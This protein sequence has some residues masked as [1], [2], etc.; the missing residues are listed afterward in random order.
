MI[1]T[2]LLEKKWIKYSGVFVLLSLVFCIGLLCCI[3]YYDKIDLHLRLN[4]THTPFED[5]FYA[6]YTHVGEWVPYVI[7]ALL[8]F[9]KAGWAS[10]LLADVL[11]SGL[12]GQIVK[13]IFNTDRP[14]LYFSR[15][16]PDIQL[17]FVD[18]VELSQWYS[19]PSGHTTTF[20]AL[21][22]TLAIVLCEWTDICTGVCRRRA[23]G[24]P[25]ASRRMKQ[26]LVGCLP[27]VDRRSTDGRIRGWYVLIDLFCFLLA[28]LGAYSRIYLN[29]HFAEDILGGAVIGV[30]TTIALLYA[31]PKI[32]NTAFWNWNLIRRNKNYCLNAQ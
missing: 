16:A 25:T 23:D 31:V 32:E 24:E 6:A 30:G 15:Y 28:V 18:G 4:A 13:Y 3:G 5:C 2:I 19:F 22:L 10:F 11:L 27:T 29:Q 26:Q 21:F 1:Y 20:F 9:Y 8:L 12:V 14:Y 17:Q 7:V